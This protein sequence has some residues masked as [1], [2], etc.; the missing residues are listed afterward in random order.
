MITCVI[1]ERGS[2]D[3]DQQIFAWNEC[4]AAARRFVQVEAGSECDN[5]PCS[6]VSEL[7]PRDRLIESKEHGEQYQ[8]CSLV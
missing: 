8:E 7:I 1:E 2:R 4:E 6:V 3:I 5:A